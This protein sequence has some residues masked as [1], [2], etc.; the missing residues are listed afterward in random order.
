MVDDVVEKSISREKADKIVEE[1][2]NK[3]VFGWLVIDINGNYEGPYKTLKEAEDRLHTKD[4]NLVLSGG[5]IRFVSNLE[6]VMVLCPS[7]KSIRKSG[8]ICSLC[9]CPVPKT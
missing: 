1:L 9:G 7:C 5:V 6:Y 4:P 8:D 3:R 2:R